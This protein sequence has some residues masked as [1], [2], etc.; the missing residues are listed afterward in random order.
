MESIKTKEL[1]VQGLRDKRDF[2]DEDFLKFFAILQREAQK[3]NSVFFL[4][5]EE[6]QEGEVEDVKCMNFTG[7]LIPNDLANAFNDLFLS[8]SDDVD[9][10]EWLRFSTGVTWHENNGSIEISFQNLFPYIELCRKDNL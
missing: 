6:G 3:Y 8:Y 10:D 9:S 7:W 5:C 1:K 4:E 2:Q